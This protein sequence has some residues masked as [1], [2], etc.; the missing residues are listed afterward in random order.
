MVWLIGFFLVYRQVNQFIPDRDP[1]ILPILAL[2]VGWGLLTIYRLDPVFGFRQT[3]WLGICLAGFAIGLRIPGLLAILRRYKYIWLTSG[4]LLALLTFFFGTYPGGNGPNLWLGCCGIYLQPSEFLKFLLIIYLAAYLADSLPAKFKLVQLLAPT[5]LIAGAAL[6][7]LVAQRDL[8]TASLFIALYTVVVYIASGKRRV[9]LFS[10]LSVFVGLVAGY[11]LFEVIQIRI[12]AWLFPWSDPNGRS[13]QIV[14]SIIAI[15]NGGLFGRGIGLGSPGVI[16]VAHSDFIFPSITEETGLLGATALVILFAIFTIRGFAI[17]LHAPNQFQRFL[18]AGITAYIITQSILIMGGTIRFLPLTGVTL[19]FVSYGG[20]SLS[21]SFFL[22]L[23]LLIIS[24]QAEDQ[25]AVIYQT[26][27]Y[28][29]IGT[30][31]LI[32]LTSII[33]VSSWWSVV[34][35]DGLLARNDNPRKF[36][37][38]QYVLRGKILDRNNNILAETIGNPGNY[39]RILHYPL[40]SNTV[41]YSNADYGQ[42]G[43]EAS[44]D[45]L[46][47]GIQENRP[48][49][50]FSTRLLTAQYPAGL[51]IRL[52]LDLTLQ[53]EA[54]LQL[55]GQ[56][57]GIV[58][59]NA[60]TG[61]VLILSTA[62]TFN[63]N[64]LELNWETW[65]GS[66]PSPLI[67]RVTQGQYPTG[68]AITGFVLARTLTHTSLP[69]SLPEITGSVNPNLS[70]YCAVT[71]GN[72]LSWKSLI[73]SG[74]T[75][76]LSDLE[77]YLSKTEMLDLFQ[78]LGFFSQVDIQL[79]STKPATFEQTINNSK[80]FSG[81]DLLASPLQMAIASA[82]L[83]NGGYLVSPKIVTGF[84]TSENQWQLIPS[85]GSSTPLDSYN[86]KETSAI[87]MEG[88]FPGWEIQ[89]VSL[90]PTVQ[91]NWYIAGT[92]PDWKGTPLVLVIALENASQKTSEEIGRAIF[93][94]SVNIQE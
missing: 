22:A 10:F 9:L 11:L 58:L 91:V 72:H 86:S 60:K 4:L 5:V 18:A 79:E 51:D 82:S 14:Q 68:N 1:Y 61:E 75:S 83:S 93:F 28:L 23:I 37:S 63:A 35:A 13:Y 94:V 59:L 2:L 55:Q 81:S 69:A 70:E 6:M 53:Q 27:P 21:T 36:I 43:L 52:S 65:K 24:N 25:P 73:R 77:K 34:R 84:Q 66:N 44:L 20:S 12:E 78:Q 19:P 54:D 8:G 17:S 64:T 62:P 32:G 3:A 33:L 26:K 80:A 38:D 71:P 50:A 45:P 15:A 90:T 47:R 87:L 56:T 30:V 76:A 29:F 49:V 67:N 39:S 92:P 7:I 41:G 88:T 16:P 42:G 57:G 46:L 89:S 48:W 85:E 40:L 74:C 31:F